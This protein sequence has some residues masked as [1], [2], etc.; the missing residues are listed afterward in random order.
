MS[1]PKHVKSIGFVKQNQIIELQ[2]LLYCYFKN[3]SISQ[4]ELKLL[5]LI[6]R[7]KKANMIDIINSSCFIEERDTDTV[8][9]Y[10]EE[11]YKT[12]QSCRNILN[13][14]LSLKLLDRDKQK[15]VFISTDIKLESEG[16]ILL[17]LKY[18]YKIL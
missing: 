17:D 5:V 14:L 7:N 6:A 15:N 8:L 2:L 11:I 16:T 13:K 12:P 9:P 4:S 18:V 1:K 10:F 3:I